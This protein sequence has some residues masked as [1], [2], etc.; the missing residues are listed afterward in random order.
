[1]CTENTREFN[2]WHSTCL[3]LRVPASSESVAEL[4]DTCEEQSDSDYASSSAMSQVKKCRVGKWR[5]WYQETAPPTRLSELLEREPVGRQEQEIHAW[6][7]E[8]ASP[9]IYVRQDD[10]LT[11]H[12][13]V[14]LK[15]SI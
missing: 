13:Q 10:P 8:D 1:M 7:R 6:N 9:N 3:Y 11:F 15:S 4:S 14:G 2:L 5:Q 12:R